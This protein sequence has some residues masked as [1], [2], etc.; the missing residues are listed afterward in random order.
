MLDST[1]LL[2]VVEIARG[3]QPALQIVQ[4]V[5][6]DFVLIAANFPEA[7]IISFLRA[8]REEAP[9]TRVVVLRKIPWHRTHF[10]DEGASAVLSQDSSISELLA[11]FISDA[12]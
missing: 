3:C 10:L 12:S 11:A 8:V 5:H 6:P 9:K 4:E 2:R 7:E 1:S